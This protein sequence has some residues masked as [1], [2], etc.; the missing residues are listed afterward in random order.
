[1]HDAPSA[2]P[3]ERPGDNTRRSGFLRALLATTYTARGS[4]AME[5][6]SLLRYNPRPHGENTGEGQ[7][8]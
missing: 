5:P 7:E 2:G 3:G 4:R 6:G 8:I 1:M